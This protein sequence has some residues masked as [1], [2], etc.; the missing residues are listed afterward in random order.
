MI[1]KDHHFTDSKGKNVSHFLNDREGRWSMNSEEIRRKF[2]QYFSSQGHSWLPSASLIP[3]EDP[4]LLFVNAGMNPLKEYFLGLKEPNH[5]RVASIQKCLRAGGKH[6]DL[7]SVGISS[8]HHTF[9]EM[10]GSFSFGDYFKKEAID[11]AW[12]FLT[13]EL[14]LPKDQLWLSV[15]EKDQETT[16]IWQK[17]AQIPS[18]KI[19]RMDEKTNFWQM[20]NKGPCGPC[21]EVYFCPNPKKSPKIS[22]CIE[23]WNLVFMSLYDDGSGSR[24]PLPRAC[25]DTGMGLERISMVL[26]GEKSTYETDLFS[27]TI[28]LLKETSQKNQSTL[29][30]KEKNICVKVLA[31]H[32]RAVSFLVA[33]G[34]RTNNEGAGYVLRRII[35]RASY[36]EQ[37]IQS[38]NQQSLLK[39]AA[40]KVISKMKT[41]YPELEKHKDQIRETILSEQNR[42]LK[43]LDKGRGILFRE[44]DRLVKNQETTVKGSMA[45]TLY[46]TYGFPFDL[47]HLIA[48]EK[49]MKVDVEGFQKEMQEAKKKNRQGFTKNQSKK[50]SYFS[51]KQIK[52]FVKR[53]APTHFTGY[54]TV[55][56]KQVRLVDFFPVDELA[57]KNSER[58]K[59]THCWVVFDRSPF[60]PEGG[61]QVGDR[62]SLITKK[63]KA[64]IL[65]CQQKEKVFLH[66]VKVMEGELKKED[67]CELQVDREKRENT[68]IHHSATHLLYAALRKVLGTQVKQAGSLV[69]EEKLRFDF[70]FPRALTDAEVVEVENL[71]NQWISIDYTVEIK[72]KSFKEAM[73]MGALAFAEDRYE[74]PVR[75]LKMGP[76]SLELCGGTHV[77]NTSQVLIFVIVSET[78]VG[79]GVRRIE[80]LA[81]QKAGTQIQQIIHHTKKIH[82]FFNLGSPFV[83]D[84]ENMLLQFIK[85]QQKEIKSLKKDFSSR[86]KFEFEDFSNKEMFSFSVKKN[87]YECILLQF[88]LDSVRQ[89]GLFADQWKNKLSKEGMIV[90]IG[91]N[92]EGK[93]PLVMSFSKKLS[94][95]LP[96][97]QFIQQIFSDL[98]G[99]GGGRAYFAQGM[100]ESDWLSAKKW[101]SSWA[102]K[103]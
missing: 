31:D 100:L 93:S 88:N 73:S 27:D 7:E 50:N 46:D 55:M 58:K 9:F 41:F 103:H 14:A 60:Y 53:Q 101:F 82:Q 30:E 18:E 87:D 24:T 64:K 16:E 97:E 74:D 37:K 54:K 8:Y 78:G 80:A 33:D 68:S 48:K 47:T 63:A 66:E 99:R 42:F 59:D 89:L 96:A 28:D 29:S 75:V 38:N 90:A 94:Q 95:V 25:I 70:T 84:S 52:D 23:I 45:F 13:K 86:Q 2:Q 5:L 15:F 83:K 20:G 39:L 4:S 79:T 43:N 62:G 77:S 49:S 85:N 35:R 11:Y 71:V 98:G 65:D 67:I 34:V 69:H 81:G 51:S 26:Q 91:E 40:N 17:V 72:H 102:K 57:G 12:Q 19:F 56:E 21:S 6:N 3:K 1:Q 10:M 61:G 22:D 44:L 32:A 76:Y 92:K 36:Y